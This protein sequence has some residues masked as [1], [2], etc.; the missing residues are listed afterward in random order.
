[1]STPIAPS[2]GSLS[3]IFGYSLPRPAGSF[4][5]LYQ[6]GAPLMLSLP[7]KLRVGAFEGRRAQTWSHDATAWRTCQ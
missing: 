6:W 7:L 3:P 5:E 4:I 1:M 2:C